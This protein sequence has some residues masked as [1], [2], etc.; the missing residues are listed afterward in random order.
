MRAFNGL[1]FVG[2]SVCA[3]LGHYVFQV[4]ASRRLSGFEFASLSAWHAHLALGFTLAGLAQYAANFH[5]APRRWLRPALVVVNAV[6]VG[7]LATWWFGLDPLGLGLGAAICLLAILYGWTMGQAQIRLDFRGLALAQVVVAVAKLT[8]PFVATGGV[9][10][11][12]F[13]IGF[14]YLPG[15]L[16]LSARLWRAPD[17]NVTGPGAWLAPVILSVAANVIPQFDLLLTRHTLDAAAFDDFARASLFYKGIYFAVAIFAQYI[18]PYQI[19]GDRRGARALW[20][21]GFAAAA[22]LG[23]SLTSPLFA[24][25][26]FAWAQPPSFWLILL[27]CVH[28]SVLTVIFMDVQAACARGAHARAAVPLVLLSL[29]AVFQLCFGLSTMHYLLFVIVIQGLTVLAGL[30]FHSGRSA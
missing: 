29:E 22:S 28:M 26:V 3:G 12:T 7:L 18:L 17:A 24:R 23:L 20:T 6:A 15:L 8:V 25:Y 30:R 11:F 14:C 27:S 19:R 10:L 1:I 16:I 2:A 4:L 9:T 21:V 13:A 5:P